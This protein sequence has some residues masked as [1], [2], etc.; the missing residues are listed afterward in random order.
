MG[1]NYDISE[2][3]FKNLNYFLMKCNPFVL[4][5]LSFLSIILRIIH[6]FPINKFLICYIYIH[7]IHHCI[8]IL[9]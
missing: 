4:V 5:N 3:F 7:K 8:L 9:Q 6:I 1:S 2:K